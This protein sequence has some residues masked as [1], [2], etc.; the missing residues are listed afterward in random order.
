MK[1]RMTLPEATAALLDI[2]R[3]TGIAPVELAAKLAP[4]VEVTPDARPLNA[5]QKTARLAYLVRLARQTGVSVPQAERLLAA[6]EV[7]K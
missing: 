2:S 4:N 5:A 6:V 3:R 1:P 7:T